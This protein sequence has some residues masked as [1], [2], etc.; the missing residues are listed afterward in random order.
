VLASESKRAGKYVRELEHEFFSQA[1]PTSIIQRFS[2]PQEIA[3]MVVYACS[4]LASSTTG[5]SLRVEGGIVTGL[6]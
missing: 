1:R 3:A 2:E 5:A 6:G 4:D